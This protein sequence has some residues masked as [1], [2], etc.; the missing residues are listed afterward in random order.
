MF[1]ELKA[2]VDDTELKIFFTTES[3]DVRGGNHNHFVIDC[4]T[5]NVN[6]VNQHIK[7]HFRWDRVDL[8]EYIPE[9]AAIFYITK[10]GLEGTAWDYLQ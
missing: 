2:G 9:E 4:N 8:E 3:Y 6:Q 10:E 5:R 1:N 7:E